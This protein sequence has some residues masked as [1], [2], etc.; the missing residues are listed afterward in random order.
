MQLLSLGHRNPSAVTNKPLQ[1]PR[2]CPNSDTWSS[3]SPAPIYHCWPGRNQTKL[4]MAVMPAVLLMPTTHNQ[5]FIYKTQLAFLAILGSDR[6]IFVQ[7]QCWRTHFTHLAP[8]RVAATAPKLGV[9]SFQ[10]CLFH[11]FQYYWSSTTCT[12]YPTHQSIAP[13]QQSVCVSEGDINSSGLAGRFVHS[14]WFAH[15]TG[16]SRG[17][18]A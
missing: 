11:M 17:F 6:R 18:I 2:C 9:S 12:Y 7:V 14:A 5:S 10:E 4:C 3:S 15:Y 13:T 1:L 16:C 8:W